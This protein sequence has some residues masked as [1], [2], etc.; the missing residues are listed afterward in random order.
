LPTGGD[1]IPESRGDIISETGGDFV[2]I[3]TSVMESPNATTAPPFA[4]ASTSTPVRAMR[5]SVVASGTK[6]PAAARSPLPMEAVCLPSQWNV[7]T[8]VGSG[9]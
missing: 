3:C 8:G 2:G 5:A 9:R 7:V 6:P 1:I 4:G